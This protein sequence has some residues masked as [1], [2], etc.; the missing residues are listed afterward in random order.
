MK[1]N[2]LYLAIIAIFATN[3]TECAQ[4]KD[5]TFDKYKELNPLI[6]AEWSDKDKTWYNT[7][8]MIK[9]QSIAMTATSSSSNLNQDPYS[10]INTDD[11]KQERD[12]MRTD[13]QNQ[14]KKEAK[15]RAAEREER[16]KIRKTSG[17]INPQQNMSNQESKDSRLQRLQQQIA[18][19]DELQSGK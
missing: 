10:E 5:N 7:S 14:R 16:Q 9:G 17:T 15:Q 11:M 18:E 3:M 6:G 12:A 1:K 2:L 4:N 8:G 19:I 13:R